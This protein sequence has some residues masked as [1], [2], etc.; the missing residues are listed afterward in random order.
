MAENSHH[1]AS[2]QS[3]D[4][5][6]K[7]KRYGGVVCTHNYIYSLSGLTE[8][9]DEA[10]MLVLGIMTGQLEVSQAVDVAY[11]NNFYFS[12]LHLKMWTP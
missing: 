12:E 4:L 3:R 8:E 9:Q 5:G 11:P 2:S 1:K 10:A 7:P 6:V